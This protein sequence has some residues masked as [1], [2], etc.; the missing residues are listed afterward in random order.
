VLGRAA[1]ARGDRAEALSAWRAV[2]GGIL[3]TRSVYVPEAARLS[4]ANQRIALL[5]AA[6]PPPGMDAGKSVE[7]LRQE[8][9]ALL[10]P[11]PGPNVFWSCVLL[12]GFALWVSAAFAFSVRALDADDR[13]VGREVR[14][15]GGLSTL[16]F[17]LFVLGMVLL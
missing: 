6:E 16:G 7:Q 10:T 5:M 14:R 17:G 13:W 8:H 15:W 11:I 9:L 2:R 3:A 12:V 1:E 4:T